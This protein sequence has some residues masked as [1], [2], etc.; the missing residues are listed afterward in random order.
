MKKLLI[1]GIMAICFA[2]CEYEI[3]ELPDETQSGANTFGCLVN[4]ELVIPYYNRH[5][6]NHKQYAVYYQIAD[7]LQIT[8][9]GQNDQ[10]FII[11]IKSP[12][13]N[14]PVSIDKIEYYPPNSSRNYF[15]GGYNIGEVILTRFD[16]MAVSGVFNFV[17]YQHSHSSNPEENLIDMNRF[18]TVS[19]GRFDI[20]LN[21]N[22]K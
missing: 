17:G 11:T 15:Y 7:S 18:V 12:K 21:V 20:A 10:F 13:I 19:M 9:Y 6:N 16:A 22:N 14:Q 1:A 5:N 8:G 3:P 2:A 4:G